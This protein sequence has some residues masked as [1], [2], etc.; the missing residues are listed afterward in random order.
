MT[1]FPPTPTSTP[2]SGPP[3]RSRLLAWLT[4]LALLGLPRASVAAP[5]VELITM[6]PGTTLFDGFGHAALRVVD[7]EAGTDLVYTFGAIA[8]DGVLLGW[9]FLRGEVL[10]ESRV[11]S[12]KKVLRSYTRQDRTIY[13]QRLAL[14]PGEHRWLA[15]RLAE[16]VL[17]ENKYYRYHH[18]RDNCSTRPRDLL[19][20]ATG[21][22]VRRALLRPSPDGR[23]IR[24]LGLEGLSLN[25]PLLLVMNVVLG[26]LTDHPT[27]GWEAAYVPARLREELAVA[28]R[29]L[30]GRV[31]PLASPVEVVYARQAPLRRLPIGWGAGLAGLLGGLGLLV[32]LL[33]LTRPASTR[34]LPRLQG[35]TALA[36]VLVGGS[37]GLALDTVA[38]S[39]L[40]PEFRINENLFLFTLLDLGLLWP[41]L[42]WLSGRRAGRLLAGTSYYLLVRG[43][44]AVG[45]LLAQVTGLL[46]QPPLTLAAMVAATMLPLGLSGLRL[47]RSSESY[48][49]ASAA[50]PPA[51]LLP[52]PPRRRK[53]AKKAGKVR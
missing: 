9:R 30:H 27:T 32:G 19:D 39:E 11:R 15:A 25:A 43:I 12:W 14:L 23:T 45:V 22:A 52:S 50:P 49:P 44:V 8:Y 48:A 1:F 26:R 34:W 17:P 47:A 29:E 35:A 41:A 36:W 18:F 28:T 53:E 24:E 31:V 20:R 6:G 7:T 33:L 46:I 21:G 16:S 40:V 42:A 3:R 4:V 5:E 38:L 51:A 13:R 37:L 2:A 10:F